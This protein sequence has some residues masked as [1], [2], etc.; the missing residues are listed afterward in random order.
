MRDSRNTKLNNSSLQVP[1]LEISKS[2]IRRLQY[3][4]PKTGVSE[5]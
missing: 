2:K 5:E 1:Y 3:L 4:F